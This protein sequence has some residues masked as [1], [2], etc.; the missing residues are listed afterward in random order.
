MRVLVTTDAV[1]GVWTYTR[2]LVTG[3]LK[4]DIEVTLVSFGALPTAA[5]TAWLDA[6]VDFRPFHF[7]LEWMQDADGDIQESSRYLE[8]VIAET[9][10]DLL[11]L[12]QY[13]YGAVGGEVPRIVVAHSDVLSWWTEVK[14]QV[15]PSSP[16]FEWYR[17]V[18]QQGLSGATAIVAPSR[19]MLDAL[20]GQYRVPNCS[21]VIYN[22][23]DPQLFTPKL[24]KETLTA[25]VGRLW[26][27]AKQVNLLAGLAD[28]F[29]VVIAGAGTYSGGPEPRRGAGEATFVGTQS[30]QQVAALL[31]RAAIYAGTSRYEPFGLAPLEAA[32]SG[33][34]LVLNDIPS[35]HEI[36]REDA[37]YFR[38]DDATSLAACIRELQAAPAL[39]RDYAQRA[40]S[41]AVSR[42]SADRMVNEYLQLYSQVA[43][44]VAA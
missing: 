35:F 37:L 1:G 22:G 43:A 26:D 36:W 32:L 41:R 31:A 38:R 9:S 17:H 42:Y 3:L 4:N 10:P 15:P 14:G 5:Q 2:E 13:C 20:C 11:H 39:R 33:C 24:A 44:G 29:Q 7:R 19:W 21:T 12:N 16:W 27:E 34:A 23:R 18:V 6:K 40:W 25:G 30:D 28:E 8:E